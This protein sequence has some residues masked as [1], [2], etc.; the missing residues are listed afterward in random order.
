MRKSDIS[1]WD[2]GTCSVDDAITVT[3]LGRTKIYELLGKNALRS[4][5]VGGR[6]LI[7]VDSLRQMIDGEAA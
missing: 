5:R 4:I 6:R 2:R 7:V 1:F 3:G